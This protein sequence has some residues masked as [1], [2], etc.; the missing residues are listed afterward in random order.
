M[1]IGSY[2]FGKL[3]FILHRITLIHHDYVGSGVLVIV[4]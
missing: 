1:I 4:E 3:Y 2:G